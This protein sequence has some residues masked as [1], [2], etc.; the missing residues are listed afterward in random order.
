MAAVQSI[1][2]LPNPAPW[3]E[4]HQ[5]G[6]KGTFSNLHK[7]SVEASSPLLGPLG[8]GLWALALARGRVQFHA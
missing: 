2:L 5:Q 1:F 6:G 8:S 7:G 4:L 3:P